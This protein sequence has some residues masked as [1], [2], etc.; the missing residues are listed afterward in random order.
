MK[1]GKF[2]LVFLGI[3]CLLVLIAL[4]LLTA[5]AS[6][7][8]AT[9]KA[10]APTTTAPQ[11]PAT[12]T[13]PASSPAAA[14]AQIFNIKFASWNPEVAPVSQT[15]KKWGANL[16]QQSGGR[17]K[18][19]YYFGE[20]LAKQ[21]DLFRAAQ[22]NVADVVH[23]PMTDITL[24]PLN[25]VVYLPFIGVP[26]ATE[27]TAIWWKLYNQFPAMQKELEGV[28]VLAATLTPGSQLSTTKK[29]VSTPADIKGMKILCRGL[30][31]DAMKGMNAAPVEQPA[32]DWYTS[33][34]RGLAEGIIMHFPGL[35]NFKLLDMLKYHSMFGAG[36]QFSPTPIA[37]SAKTFNS[38]P[39]DLQKIVLDSGKWME[40]EILVSDTKQEQDNIAQAKQK[41]NT[42]TN[43]SGADAKA[44]SDAVKPVI[45]KWIADNTAKGAPAQAI[46]DE[47]IKQI[48][49]IAK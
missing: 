2:T 17:I 13:A 39:A 19:T 8:P 48:G 49:Q 6:P 40:N 46:Y 30:W 34:D 5:C 18:V 4:P 1:K 43:V 44:W 35:V 28:K 47:C 36:C 12:S 45:D 15:Q 21:N 41:G 33:L 26:S 31:A 38:M 16:E 14:P 32:S 20:S 37:I 9:T 42:F 24:Y 25:M 11:A 7:A 10:P 3:I 27:G 23:F 22:T 29:A